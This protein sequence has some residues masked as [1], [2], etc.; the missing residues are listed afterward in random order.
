MDAI[1]RC[2][3]GLVVGYLTA[4]L[5]ES[6]A[7]Q[8]ISDAPRGSVMRWQKYP[9]LL[10]QLIETHYSH[11]TVH[12]V[13]T[14]RHDFVTQF[15]SDDDKAKVDD[16]LR[17]H[18]QHGVLIQ[19][20]GY[21]VKLQGGGAF[22]FV[23]PLLLALPLL[24][25]SGGPWFLAGAIVTMSLPPLLSNFLHPYLH[26]P[27]DVALASAPPLIRG[28]LGTR[29]MRLVAR[30]HFLHHRYVQCNF[31]LLLGGDWIRGVWRNPSEKDVT[32]MR[33]IGVPID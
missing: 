31:N 17:T 19:K 1:L 12:H 22:T 13:R 6:I 11:H 25:W 7:H 28:L 29:Y 4:S 10:R 20:A 23:F 26:M 18:G 9:R 27:H 33:R 16:E 32:E 3:S 24:Y 15:R 30:H 21:A 14:F 8:M 5:I 2:L